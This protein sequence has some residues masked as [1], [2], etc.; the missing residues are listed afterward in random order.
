MFCGTPAYMAPE[1]I[2]GGSYRG[3]P[4]D[5]W[6]MGIVLY[7]V[8][9][10]RFPFMAKHERALYK[11]V[12]AGQFSIPNKSKLSQSLRELIKRLLCVST[13]SRITMK[14]C[15]RHRWLASVTNFDRNDRKASQYLVSQD[16][17]SRDL[18][19]CTLDK[20]ESYGFR[21]ESVKSAVLNQEKNQFTTTYYL[22]HA[23]TRLS[24]SQSNS[25]QEQEQQQQQQHQ[26]SRDDG[27]NKDVQ[28]LKSSMPPKRSTTSPAVCSSNKNNGGIV[29]LNRRFK[30]LHVNDTRDEHNKKNQAIKWD[31][32][33]NNYNLDVTT[34]TTATS[35][36][37]TAT[38]QQQKKKKKR[39]VAVKY[40]GYYR[41]LKDRR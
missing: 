35:R 32:N 34:A 21:R 1:I 22:A 27:E 3:F 18:S 23:R 41:A 19:G 9:C 8:V 25:S 5:M 40:I 37:N 4:V 13:T 10:G 16:D 14:D 30:N 29:I 39:S 36:P 26:R 33:T 6:A 38:Q 24:S 7:A 31:K 12:V 17:P 20:M 15:L 2:R 28:K 11:K